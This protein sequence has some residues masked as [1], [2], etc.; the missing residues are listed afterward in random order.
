MKKVNVLAKIVQINPVRE[1][2]KSGRQGKVAS[3]LIA[4]ETSNTRLV[5]W[6][7]NHIA[8]IENKKLQENNV[9]EI[10]GGNVRNSELH[11]SSFAD[12][13]PS[14]EKLESIITEQVF[15]TKKLNQV[16]PGETIQT[17]ALIVHTFEPRYFEVCPQCG[18]KAQE[19]ECKLHGKIS[20]EKRALLSIT[21]DDG[22]ET[23]RS[24]LF[25]EQINSLGLTDEQ[26]FSLEEFNKIKESLLGE[27]MLFAGQVRQNQLYNTTDFVI[28]QVKPVN[29]QELIKELESKI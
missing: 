28:Q 16:K 12:I 2:N 9:I 6:D 25:S 5:L 21:L 7:T 29:P 14:K 3:L 1:F 19:G 26:I 18:K 8:L 20:P 4:D 24:V 22:T 11:L 23:I 27:E 10:S 13:K 15:S 17:Y